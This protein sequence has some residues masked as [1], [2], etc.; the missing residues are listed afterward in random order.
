MTRNPI[1]HPLKNLETQLIQKQETRTTKGKTKR[2]GRENNK[3][4]S[5]E[6]PRKK[7]ERKLIKSAIK[8]PP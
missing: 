4:I 5:D 2:K 3:L 1:N 6:A 7:V 8:T